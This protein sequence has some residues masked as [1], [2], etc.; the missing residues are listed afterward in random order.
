MNNFDCSMIP[1]LTPRRERCLLFKL[2]GMQFTALLGLSCSQLGW[3]ASFLSA[4]LA[5]RLR[6]QRGSGLGV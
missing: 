3:G 1:H 5:G 6:L 2:A 4:C